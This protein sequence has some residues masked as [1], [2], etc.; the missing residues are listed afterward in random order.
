MEQWMKQNR[1]A[2]LTVITLFWLGLPVC[3]ALMSENC[4]QIEGPLSRYVKFFSLCRPPVNTNLVVQCNNVAELPEDIVH[5]PKWV[6]AL[7]LSGKIK[8]MKDQAF[9][10]FPDLIYLS[11]LAQALVISP[12]AFLGLRTLQHLQIRHWP[13]AC[14]NVTIPD[15]TLLSIHS[16][17]TLDFDNICLAGQR[18]I[19]LPSRLQSLSIWICDQVQLSEWLKIFPSLR[20]VSQ[21]TIA[22]CRGKSQAYSTKQHYDISAK[23]VL[24]PQCRK[25]ET[26]PTNQ[27][28]SSLQ[29][30]KLSHFHLTLGDLLALEIEE[31][32]SLSLES[33]YPINGNQTFVL[34]ALASR[35][36]L[37]SLK[38]SQARYQRFEGEEL[39]ACRSLTSLV[40][41]GNNMENVDPLLLYKLP[42]LHLLDLS[43]NKLHWSLCP[44]MYRRT[45]FTSR[46]RVLDF[47]MNNATH[48]ST[49]AFYC[50][51][52]LRKLSLNSCGIQRIEPL[53][54]SELS[55]LEVLNLNGNGI[56]HLEKDFLP[57]LSK[58]VSLDLSG[59]PMEVLRKDFFQDLNKLREL[60][61]GSPESDLDV[62]FPA[63]NLK[64]L[65]IKS[66][67]R[68][69]FRGEDDILFGLEKLTLDCPQLEVDSCKYPLSPHMKQIYLERLHKVVF[70]CNSSRHQFL[71]H[72]PLLEHFDYRFASWKGV[73]FSHLS[74]LRTLV[75]F[76]LSSTLKEISQ[77]DAQYLFQNLTRL[78]VMHLQSSG[79][80]FI[81]GVLFRDMKNLRLLF[82]EN[83]LLLRLDSGFQAE[84][85]Q[86][87]YLYLRDI[88]FG[89]YCSNAWFVT[90]ASRK[91]DIYVDLSSSVRCQELTTLLKTQK[92]LPF[93]E[94]NCSLKADFILFLLTFF[95]VLFLISLSLVHATCSM[96]LFFLIYLLRGWWQ[97]LRGEM[98]KGKRF[99]YDAFVSYCSHDQE[100][101]LQCLVPNLEQ[102][103]LSHLKLCLH[104][105]DFV[106]GKA[107]VDN[108]MDNLYNSW[109]T[110]CVIS[111]HSLGSHWC[112]LE[113]SLATYR[114][115]AGREDTLI[116]VFLGHVSRYRLSAYHRLAKLLKKNTY[117][118]WPED[119]A[120][121]PAFWNSLR[122]SFRR[123]CQ[124]EEAD[125]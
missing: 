109:K 31:L 84:M 64:K 119:P 38:F 11:L 42:Q 85:M 49:G 8:L 72:F 44:A 81:S 47:S 98:K 93:V 52:Y 75:V 55:S 74:N 78:E 80:Q 41:Q 100:W 89:C 17:Q 27:S 45:N 15:D 39:H 54:F 115:L 58:L 62:E 118:K 87:K 73:N 125:F 83:D 79:L 104:S 6:Q 36:S 56:M 116:L 123:P 106:V 95:L 57:N 25:E 112:S 77:D 12:R 13:P 30:L 19:M 40:L 68:I 5:V 101:V 113:M 35:F 108:I 10:A 20:S 97:R 122:N 28:G 33:T 82:L 32:D 61:L 110:I 121:E 111:R 67:S 92:F 69:R 94:Q 14:I 7:C 37:R 124:V 86:L 4:Q 18:G 9:Q 114:H 65:Q 53:A 99:Q 23:P 29:V 96:E 91:E 120:A 51:A 107:T 63:L 2:M 105:R 60:S 66:K 22:K 34:C 90:W 46:L 50:L 88:T 70:S 1:Q 76:H 102:K 103:G 3:L 117:L 16:L 59:N 48:V 71:H 21:V 26:S 43:L 24:A